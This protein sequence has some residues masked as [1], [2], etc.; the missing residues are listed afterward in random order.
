M[1]VQLVPLL[2]DKNTPL[3][4]VTKRFEPLTIKDEIVKLVSPVFTCVQLVPLYKYTP[5]PEVP[6]KRFD[7]LTLMTETLSTGEISVQFAPLLVDK[8]TPSPLVPA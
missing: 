4:V 3:V 2:V 8:N 5:A 1:A 6:T 7:P